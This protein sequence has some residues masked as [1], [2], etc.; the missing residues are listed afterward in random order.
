MSVSI[1]IAAFPD[2]GDNGETLVRHAAMWRRSGKNTLLSYSPFTSDASAAGKRSEL[3]SD[4]LEQ[5]EWALSTSHSH[6]GRGR[7]TPVR[8]SCAGVTPSAGC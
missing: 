8:R 6:A 4:A 5:D 3:I 2:D 7:L 1:G